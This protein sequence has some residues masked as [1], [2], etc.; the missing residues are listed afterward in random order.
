MT[1]TLPF[2]T[3]LAALA[4]IQPCFNL[5]AQGDLTPQE[6]AQKFGTLMR[7]VSQVYVDSV[8]IETLTEQAIVNMLEDLDPHSVY[9]S[10]D[11]LK[12]AD[13]PLN[14]NF[15]GIGVQFN[16]FK[17]T[18]MVVSPISGVL[19]KNS[20]SDPETGLWRLMAKMRPALASPTEM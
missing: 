18:I 3:L 20:A 9:F 10:A 5:L 19:L 14:G 16:I 8:D 6:S 1:R 17:D 15:E 7:Y 2:H 4:F 12:E 11:E 13:E